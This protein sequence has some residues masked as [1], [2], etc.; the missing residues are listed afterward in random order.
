MIGIYPANLYNKPVC[1]STFRR[2]IL[3]FDHEEL[4]KEISLAAKPPALIIATPD[5]PTAAS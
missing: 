5:S 1:I 3:K 2:S 4:I